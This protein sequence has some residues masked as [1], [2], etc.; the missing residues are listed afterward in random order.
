MLST[1]IYVAVFSA[2]YRSNKD[3]VKCITSVGHG[4]FF[5]FFK[6][7]TSQQPQTWG[8]IAKHKCV[9]QATS[10]K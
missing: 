8:D 9:R 10:E 7:Q 3:T 4:R 2:V 6:K 1:L 5:F